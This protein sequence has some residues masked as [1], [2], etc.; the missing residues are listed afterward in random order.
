[1]TWQGD[2]NDNADFPDGT[3]IFAGLA[4]AVAGGGSIRYSPDGDCGDAEPDAAIVVFGEEP[5]AEGFGDRA[6]LS[7]SAGNAEPLAILRRLKA[8]GIPTVAVFV[9]GRPMWVNPELNA[10]D[11]FVVAWLPGTEGGGIADVL[12]RGSDGG[13]AHDF[14]GRLSFSWPAHA[15][16]TP[17][18]VGDA[19]Y[20]PLF[21]YGFGLRYADPPSASRRLDEVD[22]AA[23]APPVW[24]AGRS[25][26]AYPR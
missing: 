6:H 23:G 22:A 26:A 11:A 9:T 19:G 3:S 5:Y 25:D 21:P 20:A 2:G 1:M 18:N 17:L 10:S 4:E 14:H 7:Y 15:L 16:H 8:R 24:A 13:I 12:F